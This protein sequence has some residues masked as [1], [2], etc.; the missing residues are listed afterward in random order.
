MTKWIMGVAVVAVILGGLYWYFVTRPGS[1]APATNT[2]ATTTPAGPDTSDTAMAQDLADIHG[3]I[4]ANVEATS[5][6]GL[7]A[8]ISQTTH[9][10]DLMANLSLKLSMRVS[11]LGTSSPQVA[12]L[13]STLTD[14]NTQIAD[15]HTQ[16]SAALGHIANATAA[17]ASASTAKAENG[18]AVADM[19][20]AKQD[21]TAALKDFGTLF[22]GLNISTSTPVTAPTTATTTTNT[23]Q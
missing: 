13:S 22:S 11:A 21:F 2:A 5:T 8:Q 19:R 4:S 18:K 17:D 1:Q 3:A 20:V 7:P 15:A 23:L 12:A 9:V 16:S 10:A 14:L 6:S